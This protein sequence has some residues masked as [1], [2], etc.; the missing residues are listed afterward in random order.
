M[1]VLRASSTQ[2]SLEKSQSNLTSE[3][4]ARGKRSWNFCSAEA[5]P[6][7]FSGVSEVSHSA[8]AR[9]ACM[10]GDSTWVG[11][12]SLYPLHF[13]AFLLY[14]LPFSAI[15]SGPCFL[16][17]SGVASSA[18]SQRGYFKKWVPSLSSTLPRLI[19]PQYYILKTRS[20][21][22]FVASPKAWFSRTRYSSNTTWWRR[23][24]LMI[25]TLVLLIVLY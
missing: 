18:C 15:W 11:S 8:A 10:V 19:T 24:F 2:T 7:C 14:K 21:F 20:V 5:R 12:G 6:Y 23:C 16:C 9:H 25:H 17:M 3:S 22:F 13:K 4:S 1:Y